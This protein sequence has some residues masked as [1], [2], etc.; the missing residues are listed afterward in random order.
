MRFTAAYAANP[1][2]SPTRYSLLTGKY[3]TRAGLTNFLSGVRATERFLEAPLVDGMP[4]AETTTAEAVKPAGYQTAFVGKWHLGAAVEFWPEAQGF[5]MNVGGHVRGSP[6]TYFSPYQNP[7]LSDGP[8]G[9]YLTARLADESIKLL[10]RFKATGRPFLL[11][12]HFYG[13]HTPLQAPADLIEKYQEKAARLG[14]EDAYLEETQHFISAKGPRRVRGVQNHA[15]YAAM[16]ESMDTAFGRVLRRLDDL[17]L[18]ESTLVIFVSDNGG[19]STTER[20]PT[21]NLPLRGGK[22]W[23]YEGGIR[24]PFLVRMPG[25][26]PP[27]R[28]SDVPVMTTDVFATVLDF[29]GVKPPAGTDGRSLMPLLRGGAPPKRDALHWHFPHYANQGG[30]PGGAIRMGDWKLIEN[31]ENGAVELYNLRDD[32]GERDDLAAERPRRVDA[33]RKRLHSWYREVG[34]Q[35]LRA[36]PGGPEPWQ[37]AS[38]LPRREKTADAGAPA[39]QD[40][41][42]I[43]RQLFR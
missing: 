8:P 3:P 37:P 42:D 4:L 25:M 10:E 35:F 22:G 13:V 7:R 30:F 19:Y 11:H 29:A 27:G 16:V 5:D 23:V 39:R 38:P 2:C 12:H 24:I 20:A 17:G 21:S 14:L 18:A 6:T 41:L 40:G 28:T 26:A 1:V 33:L 31:Y 15:V 32:V 9:E 43:P 36:K 34:A